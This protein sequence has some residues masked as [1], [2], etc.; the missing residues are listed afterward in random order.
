MHNLAIGFHGYDLYFDFYLFIALGYTTLDTLLAVF[1]WQP[2]VMGKPIYFAA[3]ITIFFFFF[4][5]FLA[6]S[7][8]LEIGRLPY[9]YT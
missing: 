1:L 6:Y 2:I 7:Q 8:W 9:F 3:V 5:F 4:L